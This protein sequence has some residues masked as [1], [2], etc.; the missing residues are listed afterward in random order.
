MSTA[1]ADRTYDVVLYGATGF[2][3]RQTAMYFR[4]HAPAR[5]RWAIAGR[6]A[7]K[8][9]ALHASMELPPSVGVVVADS[10]DQ[11]ALDAM[12]AQ[13]LAAHELKRAFGTAILPI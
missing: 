4:E 3:G 1:S 13:T 12:A 2:T 9:G 10:S 8:L 5:V 11:A 6:N 7:D